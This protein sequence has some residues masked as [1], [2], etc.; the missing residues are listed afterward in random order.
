MIESD[1]S[2]SYKEQNQPIQTMQQMQANQN[3]NSKA[4]C[5]MQLMLR[6]LQTM[7][8]NNQ[9]ELFFRSRKH[10]FNEFHKSWLGLFKRIFKFLDVKS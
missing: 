9:Q 6:R 2:A 8:Y 10:L 3:E 4:S 1:H 5:D 7:E